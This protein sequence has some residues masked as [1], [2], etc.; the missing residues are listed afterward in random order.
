MSDTMTK[1]SKSE[2]SICIPRVFSGITWKQVKDTMEQ[3]LGK[4]CIER[5][6]LIKK[7]S[8][9]GEPFGRV[10][11]HFRYW[12]QTEEAQEI[13]QQLLAGGSVKIVYDDPWFW[14]CSMSR[15]PKPVRERPKPVPYVEFDRVGKPE[16]LAAVPEG[17]GADEGGDEGTEC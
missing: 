12:P 11:I 14:K 17:R 8:E 15:V 7:T 6:D 3:V 13:R 1:L 5:V 9:D 4:A 16:V 10:F 2:P